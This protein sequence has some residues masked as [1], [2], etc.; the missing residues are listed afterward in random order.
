MGVTVPDGPEKG[1]EP[2]KRLASDPSASPALLTSEHPQESQGENPCHQCPSSPH[3]SEEEPE[4]ARVMTPGPGCP[5]SSCSSSIS[6]VGDLG[7][8][9]GPLC[10][11]V[12]SH[13]KWGGKALIVLFPGLAQWVTLSL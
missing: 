11:S 5:K 8:E 9:R 10:A 12:Y 4:E 1:V 6:Y 7:P 3:I 2:V 13:V